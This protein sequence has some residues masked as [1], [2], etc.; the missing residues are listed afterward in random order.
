MQ[1][2]FENFPHRIAHAA[3]RLFLRI[4]LPIKLL[5]LFERRR[6][7]QRLRCFQPDQWVGVVEL[8]GN[9]FIHLR[10]TQISQSCAM[11]PDGRRSVP[12]A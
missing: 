1:H 6:R 10:I 7:Q 2:A 12:S 9:R 5:G 8:P 3:V 11:L 4:E